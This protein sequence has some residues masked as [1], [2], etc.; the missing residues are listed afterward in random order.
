MRRRLQREA[1]YPNF[2]EYCKARIKDFQGIEDEKQPMIEVKVI[3][4]PVNNLHPT[5]GPP[6]ASNRPPLKCACRR[7]LS[8]HMYLTCHSQTSYLSYATSSLSL[9]G[10]Q[11]WRVARHGF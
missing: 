1:E 2:L 7:C 8:A 9:P 11:S 5:S 3:P 4:A 6:T 10:E